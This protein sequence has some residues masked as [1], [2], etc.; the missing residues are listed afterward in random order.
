MPLRKKLIL[1]A[2]VAYAVAMVVIFL[3]TYDPR[4][5]V[6]NSTAG[7]GPGSSAKAPEVHFS[8]ITLKAGIEFKHVTG[9]YG[10]ILFPEVNGP[11]CGFI[12]YDNDGDQDL[13]LVNSGQW[14]HRTPGQT[15][16]HSLYQNDGTGRFTD[17]GVAM[18]LVGRSYGQGVC[19]GDYDNDG[20]IDIYVTCVGENILYKNI[21][22]QR[23]ENVTDKVHV[24]DKRWSSSATFLD[25]DRDGFLDLFVANYVEWSL[26]MEWGIHSKEVESKETRTASEIPEDLAI[27]EN[28][29]VELPFVRRK[30]LLEEGKI[31]HADSYAYTPDL[32]PA[33][34]CT[35][36]K[37]VGGKY[38]EDVSDQ[39]GIRKI[40]DSS[41]PAARA[42]A[43]AAF[44]VNGDNWP[45]IAVANDGSE[46][47][48][49]ENTGKGTF[50]N[51][52]GKAGIAT[53]N[54]GKTRAGMGLDWA[55]YLNDSH[56]ALAVS[57]YSGEDPGFY[58]QQRTDFGVFIDFA[59]LEGLSRA[60]EMVKWGIFFFDFDLDGRQDLFLA[61]GHITEGRALY[62]NHT[63]KEKP[64]LLWN[65]GKRPAFVRLNENQ[66]GPEFFVE[67]VARGASYGDID[68]DG[69]LDVLVVTNGGPA[70]LFRNDLDNGK[71]LRLK[72]VGK[73]S[74][75]SAIGAR[76]TVHC[77]KE[78]QIREVRGGA[79]YA[80][81]SEMPL[82][83]G[84]GN[85]PPVSRIVVQWPSGLIEEY[86]DLQSNK[87]HLLQEGDGATRTPANRI[88]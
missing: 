24:G 87:E 88:Q 69:D 42:L 15:V 67:M 70:Y 68:L 18:G 44:D 12:D 49:F 74:N 16:E 28:S 21:D 82:T 17:V 43:V 37:N 81:Q 61:S 80:S 14:P 85:M 10:E 36:Y 76:V 75:R 3:A 48:L 46:N 40:N 73:E 19:F 20:Y 58:V 2:A 35:L 25:Y 34:H 30:R 7:T 51:T 6:D 77:G 72:L 29:P 86:F 71:Y 50:V 60:R 79:S 1:G 41:E 84:L 4:K 57:N 32:F 47:F 52:A 65:S 56:L 83:F 78:Q 64:I 66:V 33:T 11:G 26:E 22:G 53:S 62:Q 8:D 39:S 9:H 59:V 31:T 38:F 45:D 27:P 13:F 5:S 55:Y 23:F 54:T 63:Y